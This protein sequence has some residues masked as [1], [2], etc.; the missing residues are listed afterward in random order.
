[1]KE[2]DS[3]KKF[4]KNSQGNQ[5]NFLLKKLGNNAVGIFQE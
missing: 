4:K 2:N 3:F 5:Q 1:M